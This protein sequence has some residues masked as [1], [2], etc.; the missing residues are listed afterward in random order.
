LEASIEESE[1][2]QDVPTDILFQCELEFKSQL[3]AAK[4]EGWRLMKRRQFLKY[5][6][7]SGCAA[8]P[9]E[10]ATTAALSNR[11]R[12][13]RPNLLILLSDEHSPHVLGCYGDSVVRTP[14]LDALASRGVI[15]RNSYCASPLCVPSRTA[16]LTGQQP[17]ATQVWGNDDTLRS[18]IPTFAHS[19]GAAGYDTALIGRMHFQG[20]DQ[21][22][23]FGERLV[24]EVLPLYPYLEFPLSPEL[25]QGARGP[26]P[27]S[28][29]IAGPGKTAYEAYDEDVT[30]SAIQFLRERTKIGTKPFCAVVGFVLP[31]SPF[32]CSKTEWDYYYDRVS[33]P[34]LP[35]DYFEH[36][37]PAMQR[38]RKVHEEVTTEEVRR[39]RA[40]YYGLVTE[41]DRQIGRI[42]SELEEH[43]FARKTAVLY[44]SDHG[45]MAGEHGMWYKENFYEASV[46]VPLIASWPGHWAPTQRHEVTS[47]IHVA[48]TLLELAKAD[49]L[50]EATGSSLLPLLEGQ[51]AEW[52]D[53][54]LS[55]YAPDSVRTAMRMIRSGRWK[56]VHYDDQQP[57]LFDLE[58][59]P[60][61]FKD[62]A[63]EAAYSQVREALMER[64]L[65]G[66]SAEEVKRGTDRRLA[67][68]G[69]M[70][71]WAEMV[72]PVATPQWTAPPDAN[73]F[74]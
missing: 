71:R 40:G 48:P 52:V 1:V 66:W 42:L 59:D 61:E 57:Q 70:E 46:A 44:T 22:H 68:K 5:V 25:A 24:G 38:W 53:E 17:S 54:A 20:M 47:L 45:E 4:K 41:L 69:I 36:L 10:R 14:N 8:F 35:A 18:D 37:H 30:K 13:D 64:A 2:A 51:K 26:L 28:I 3:W 58:S 11:D 62:L 63:G 73:R 56:L 33:I 27:R 21:W 16:F 29:Q 31:H 39:A 74:P 72:R 32:V 67:W 23:G 55:E 50:P 12:S 15:F 49:P 7:A 65:S 34:Q 6:G 43:D 9:L 60:H 19:L